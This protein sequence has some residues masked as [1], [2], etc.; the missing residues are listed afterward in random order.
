MAGKLWKPQD[1]SAASAAKYVPGSVIKAVATVED[2]IYHATAQEA[3][4]E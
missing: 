1:P 4:A 3:Q 2:D